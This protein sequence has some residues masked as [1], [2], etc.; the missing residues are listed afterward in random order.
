MVEY[1]IDIKG[2]SYD[3]ILSSHR[4]EDDVFNDML[5]WSEQRRGINYRSRPRAQFEFAAPGN[6]SHA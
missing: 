3:E 1:L 4:T 5:R 2:L 6:C